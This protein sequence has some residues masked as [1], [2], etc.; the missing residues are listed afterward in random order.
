MYLVLPNTKDI[1]AILLLGKMYYLIIY[2]SKLFSQTTI[3]NVFLTSK[4]HG[5]SQLY[6]ACS[7]RMEGRIGQ[8]SSWLVLPDLS[9]LLVWSFQG[10]VW[11]ERGQCP[12]ESWDSF[13]MYDDINTPYLSPVSKQTGTTENMT[14]LHTRYLVSKQWIFHNGLA[15]FTLISV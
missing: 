6:S 4:S 3:V 8:V 7:R 1:W 14:C 13:A 2:A 12:S 9:F 10:V 15:F 11:T 5:F